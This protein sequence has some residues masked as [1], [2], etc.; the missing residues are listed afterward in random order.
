MNK[1]LKNFFLKF[2]DK[3]EINIFPRATVGIYSLFK[4]INEKKNQL[5]FQAQ[6]VLAQFMLLFLQTLI[7]YFVT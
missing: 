7:Q 5:F 2:T 3:S 4:I 1:T 6:Y